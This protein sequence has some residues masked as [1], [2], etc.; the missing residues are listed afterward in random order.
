MFKLIV[1]VTILVILVVLG[2]S[3][4]VL[5]H[6]SHRFPETSAGHN[7]EMRKRGIT[8]PKDEDFQCQTGN[9]TGQC[10]VC[11]GPDL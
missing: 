5:F 2:L 9:E 8:C 7:S 10:S 11:S 6:K 4:K 3:I 1:I